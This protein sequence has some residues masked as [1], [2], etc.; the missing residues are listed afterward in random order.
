MAK[1]TKKKR[2]A[3][4]TTTPA[5]AS[6]RRRGRWKLVT[7]QELDSWRSEKGIPK[8]RMAELLGV[9][10]STY[11]NWARKISIPTAKTQERIRRYLDGGAPQHGAAPNGPPAAR[12]PRV[13]AAAMEATGV[14]VESYLKASKSKV[15]ADELK[16][17]IVDVRRALLN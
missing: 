2:G 9:T 3:K 13:A 17:L 6:G 10:N 8:K 16:S 14:I 4:A 11:H 5:S 12:D 15:T 1:K 7:F